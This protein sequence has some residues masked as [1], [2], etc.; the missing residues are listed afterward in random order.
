MYKEYETNLEEMALC[1]FRILELTGIFS[2]DRF[3]LVSVSTP[4]SFILFFSITKLWVVALFGS[5]VLALVTWF[6]HKK[7]FLKT[8]QK[9]IKLGLGQDPNYTITYSL[10][11]DAILYSFQDIEMKIFWKG[12]KE[13]IETEDFIELLF[14][15]T[16][17]VRLPKRIF[18]SDKEKAEWLN[19]I[20]EHLN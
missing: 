13:V 4:I 10:G 17:I 14:E 12:L 3:R 15:P 18:E 19:F 6:E 20:K 7:T 2:K 16:A 5:L 8:L 11:Q 9:N 1:E